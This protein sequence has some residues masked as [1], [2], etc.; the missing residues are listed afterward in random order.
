MKSD[1]RMRAQGHCLLI[2]IIREKIGGPTGS[3]GTKCQYST[4]AAGTMGTNERGKIHHAEYLLANI[5]SN[6]L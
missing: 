1:E 5:S 2:L 6:S 4:T 3:R